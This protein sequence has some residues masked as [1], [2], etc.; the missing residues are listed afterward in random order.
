VISPV[1][2]SEA[3]GRLLWCEAQS[4]SR[5]HGPQ[6]HTLFR[7]PL[8]PCHSHYQIWHSDWLSRVNC[9]RPMAAGL[10]VAV[11][12]ATPSIFIHRLF[13]LELLT[14]GV[15][16]HGLTT[17]T[18]GLTQFSRSGLPEPILFYSKYYS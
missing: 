12:F 13:G 18:N 15:T 11:I 16:Y 14:G 7:P 2:H 17:N 6:A 5:K 8:S 4:N 10:C 3:S 9:T 1:T